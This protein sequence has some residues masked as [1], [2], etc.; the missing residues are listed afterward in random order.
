MPSPNDHQRIYAVGDIHGRHDLLKDILHQ[1]ATDNAARPAADSHLIFLGDY[2][3]R[4]PDSHGVVDTLLYGLP[5]GF[6]THFLMGNH[7]RLL[8][9]ALDEEERMPLWLANGGVAMLSSYARASK[10]RESIIGVNGAGDHMLPIDHR[11]FFEGLELRLTCGDYLFVHAG[12]RP[13]VELDRQSPHDLLWIR[14]PFLSYDGSF[15]KIVVHGHTP[16][17]APELKPNRIGIDTG[18]VFTGRLTAIRL[19]GQ[20]QHLMAT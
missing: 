7:E 14:E 10:A 12:V 2:I 4:G 17:E 16:V 8:L 5:K 3:D 11:A 13:G 1:I 9:D 15:G 19:E 20:D 6:Q 18:A